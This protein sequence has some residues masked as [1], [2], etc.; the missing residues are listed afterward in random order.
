MKP[1]R[2]SLKCRIYFLPHPSFLVLENEIIRRIFKMIFSR[3]LI[4]HRIRER[5]FENST[6]SRPISF[7]ANPFN[8]RDASRFSFYWN[9]I[10]TEFLWY[11]RFLNFSENYGD[12]DTFLLVYN[13]HVP[14]FCHLSPFVTIGW[15]LVINGWQSD[16]I[17]QLE[18]LQ[19]FG[20]PLKPQNLI[21]LHN[22]I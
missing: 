19:M 14:V 4:G 17:F 7:N 12:F 11:L 21:F 15:Q 9:K 5:Q 6:K 13:I 3:F 2:S 22:W 10:F 20:L 16:W 8:K 1:R 18:F